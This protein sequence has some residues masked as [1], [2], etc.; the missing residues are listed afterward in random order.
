MYESTT[1]AGLYEP[2]TSATVLVLGSNVLVRRV[3]F[4]VFNIKHHYFKIIF[5]IGPKT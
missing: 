5:L 1:S 3:T 2:T 4:M